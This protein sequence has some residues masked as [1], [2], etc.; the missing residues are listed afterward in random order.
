MRF[1]GFFFGVVVPLAALVVAIWAASLARGRRQPAPSEERLAALEEQVRGLL[2]RVWALEQRR[3][4]APPAAAQEPDAE[5]VEAAPSRPA[6]AAPAAPAAPPPGPPIV[7][8]APPGI[9]PAPAPAPVFE[10]PG[11]RPRMDLEQRI[12]ARWAT[13]VGVV[14][15]VVAV[16]LFLKW[17][18]DNNLLGP[19]ARVILGLAAGGASLIGGL[20]LHRRRDLPYLSEGLAGLG[21]ALLYLSLFAA[22]ALWGL[23][24]VGPAFASMAAVTLLGA[25]VAVASSRQVTAVLAV[26][27]GLLTPVLLTVEQPDER[28]LLAYLLVLDVLVLAVARW[29]TW[30]ALNRV[31]WAGTAALLAPT[32]L[33][34]LAA[35][36][37]LTRLV[38]LSALFALFLLV[39]LLRERTERRRYEEIDLLLVVGNAAGYFWAVYVTLERWRPGLEWPWAL[40]LAIVYRLVAADYASRVSDDEGTIIV[41]EGIAWTFLTLTFPLAFDGHWVTFAWAAQGV[42]LL[43][44]T[45]RLLT[46]VAAWGGLAALL[47][48]AVR[49]AV[50]DRY[51]Y[52]E[53]TPVWNLAFLVHLLVVL[54][55]AVGGVLVGQAR[56]PR[57]GAP[58]EALR[59]IL[60]FV[61]PIV[62]AVLL[63]RE[64]SDL[65]PAFLL[66]AELVL[67]GSL[68]RGTASPGL[69][70]ATLVV[71]GTVLAR[72]LIADD[73][74]HRMAAE[75]LLNAPL[76]ARVAA[77]A[78]LALAGGALARTREW[79]QAAVLG[80]VLSGVA[81][82]AL[83]YVLSV[84]WTRYQDV[85]LA[86]ARRARQLDLAG[87]IRWRTQVGLSVLWTLYAA[88]ALAWGFLR[89]TA[90]VRYAAL[91]LFG[92]TVFKVFLVDMAAVS[93]AWRIVSFLILGL[94]LLGVSLL[95]QKTRQT[96]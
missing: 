31:A 14:A 95:Y 74:L 52:P 51:W 7:A 64:P 62:L 80:R 37:P 19:K 53:T 63:W 29:R 10:P 72:T 56:S 23:L 48:A 1:G 41:H 83:L 57:L 42:M 87:E 85:A 89:A 81:G 45:R 9:P 2:Y 58:A 38:L 76:G 44:A 94:V 79:A 59:T 16:A 49:A 25:L 93:T 26:L 4:P 40:A 46:P 32:L 21:L 30:P 6:W 60:W 65:W 12:G 54:A 84:N 39:P 75:S 55:A 3:P 61:A 15:L 82:L 24:S 78:A 35:P 92:L 50:V 43:W 69:V 88:L 73:R 77:C 17:S 8:A 13:W 91:G 86:A 68:A 90:A 33:R 96:A 67:V 36:H 66:S 20:A 28:N 22:H 5:P 18:F 47:M 34:D 11:P 71:A 27:G 70:A